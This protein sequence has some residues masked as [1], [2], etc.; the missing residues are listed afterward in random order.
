MISFNIIDFYVYC[1]NLKYY[2]SYHTF[3]TRH[4]YDIASHLMTCPNQLTRHKKN[5]EV[6]HHYYHVE[7][8]LPQQQLHFSAAVH[9]TT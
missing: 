6:E 8:T 9:A 3:S 1:T 5:I 7:L 2:I 4:L